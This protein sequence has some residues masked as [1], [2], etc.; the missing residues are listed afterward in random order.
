MN[1]IEICKEF[2]KEFMSEVL[3]AYRWETLLTRLAGNPH[4][5]IAHHKSCLIG[6]TPDPDD[7]PHCKELYARET[8]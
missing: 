2:E 6:L 5:R 1:R 4:T 8:D 7:C 3:P